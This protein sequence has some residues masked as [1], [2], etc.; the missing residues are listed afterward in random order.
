MINPKRKL[1][2]AVAFA[3]LFCFTSLTGAQPLYAIPPNTQ[4]PV[5]DNSFDPIGG[6][7]I[8][9][10]N[11]IKDNI[12]NIT[13]TDETSI[14]KW[15]DFSIGADAIVNFTRENGGTFNS[16]NFVNSGAVSEIYGQLT[17]L[18]GNIFIANPAGV[19]IGNSAQINVGSLYV[20]N[21]KL[22]ESTLLNALESGSSTD[23]IRKHLS[24]L[25]TQSTAQL[26]SLGAIT[27]ATNVTFDGARIVLDTDRIY[28]ANETTGELE[29]VNGDWF[30]TGLDIITTD[31]DNVVLGSSERANIFGNSHFN[32][33]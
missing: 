30:K 11:A 14:I 1:T 20:T 22:D 19:T 8:P 28:T 15:K 12:M 23:D 32:S 21:K 31:K 13:Q 17:A 5:L 2:R 16:L 27:N 24:Q 9:E 6:V 26:M 25:N 3:I 7:T 18:G 4:L 10:L 33:E 29:Q